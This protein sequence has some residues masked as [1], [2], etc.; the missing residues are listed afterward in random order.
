MYKYIKKCLI[1][2]IKLRIIFKVKDGWSAINFK[3]F[4][5]ILGWLLRGYSG[6]ELIRS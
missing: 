4:K 6:K 2:R 5:R 1:I 3:E